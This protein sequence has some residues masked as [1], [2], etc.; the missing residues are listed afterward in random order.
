M[1]IKYI[2][3]LNLLPLILFLGFFFPNTQIYPFRGSMIIYR[4][5]ILI[6]VCL[7]TLFYKIINIGEIKLGIVKYINWVIIIFIITYIWLGISIFE[8]AVFN[9]SLL[10]WLAFLSFLFFCGIYTSLM[11]SRV[12]IVKALIPI[13]YTF[14]IIVWATPL[15]ILHYTQGIRASLGAVNGFFVYTNQLGHFL[16]VFGTPSIVYLLSQTQERRKRL[17]LV[18]TLGLSVYF[19]IAS[20]AR[21]ATVIKPGYPGNSAVPL[22]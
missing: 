1:K 9:I 13:M 15:A 6:C 11:D 14:V 10:K 2:S 5:W 4:W 18:A 7:I 16:A 20:K 22:G 8:S 19:T 12:K 21:V 3:V 17:F